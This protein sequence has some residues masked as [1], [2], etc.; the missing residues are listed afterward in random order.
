MSKRGKIGGLALGGLILGLIAVVAA[1][2]AEPRYRGRTLSSWLQE[3]SDTPL[4]ETQRLAQAQEAVRAIG[5]QKALPMLL[6]LVKT[7]D[8]PVSTWMMD[9]TEK[10]RM[11]NLH[12]RSAIERQLEGIAGFE[13]LGTNCAAAVGE[14]TKL[15][16]DKELAFVA[17]R[18]LDNVGKSAERALCQC[19]TNEDWQVRHLSVSALASVTDDV[20]VYISRIKPRLSDVEPGVRF[21]TVQAIA[22]QN[23]APELA[24]PLL[25]SA[26][27]DA[28]DGVCA[29]A[30]GGLAGFGTNASSAFPALTNLVATGRDGQRRAALKA[31]ASLT[32]GEALP[33][34]SNAVVSGSA[35]TMGAALRDMKSVA[36]ELA[37]KMTLA[38]FHSA[39]A[40]RR[41]VALSVAGT[42]DVRTPGI[43]EAL[44]S[45]VSSDEPEVARHAMMTMRQML[46]K[47]KEK[48]GAVVEMP[49]EPSYQGKQL[50][51]WLSMRRDGWE[52]AT[53]AVQALQAM[54]TN[55]IPALLVRLAY[56]EPVFG[57]DDYDVSMSGATALMAMGGQ[58]KAALPKLSALMDSDNGDLAL[59]AMI[60][61]LGT[62][63]DAMPFLIKGLTN[64]FPTV[65]GEA[66]SF[67]MQFGAQYPEEQKRA[68]PEMMKLLNDPDRDVR[69]S[70]TNELN[71]LNPRTAVRAGVK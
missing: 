42:Y 56:K 10:Y 24:V 53:N 46:R 13:V 49:N 63:A 20:E 28:D 37:L 3:C 19:L 51:E 55:V 12:W 31:L 15:L 54:G 43:A 71:E 30:T 16:G 2:G 32:P 26:L 65:R 23:E 36:P 58:A 57:L 60:A 39:D 8:D 11:R 17:A 48:P 14:L 67:L 66:V 41:S 40:R 35:Q 52:L 70:V 9:K 59:R 4:M 7:K 69:M 33:I 5:A 47:E 27:R 34:L 29:Q 45:A 1:H 6:S 25:I 22:E 50:G 44:K 21:A 62:G 18:C 64:R 61:T 68:I 38:E